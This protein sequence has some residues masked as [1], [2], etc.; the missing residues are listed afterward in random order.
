MKVYVPS[1]GYAGQAELALQAQGI[2]YQ[3]MPV[4]SGA[5]YGDRLR[6]LWQAGEGFLMLEHDIIPVE[7]AVERLLKCRQPW[8]T[9]AYPGPQLFMSIGVLKLS[10]AAVRASQDL[11]QLWAGAHWGHID[12]IMVPALHAR[13]PLHGHYPPF[14]HERFQ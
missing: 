8:C 7:G 9:H 12:G 5:G 13:F 14:G 6:E 3:T 4:D 10:T 1:L 11:P 2:P